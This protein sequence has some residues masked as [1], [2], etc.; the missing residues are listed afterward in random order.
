LHSRRHLA[1]LLDHRAAGD[2][3][4]LPVVV[5]QSVTVV[6]TADA[7]TL[8]CDQGTVVAGGSLHCALTISALDGSAVVLGPYDETTIDSTTGEVVCDLPP[9]AAGCGFETQGHAAVVPFTVE[10]GA[11]V[12]QQTVTAQIEGDS[13]DWLQAN[14]ASA[15]FT[16]VAPTPSA[17]PVV[18][19]PATPAQPV[20]RAGTRTTVSCGAVAYR[21]AG[22]C[23][24]TVTATGGLP[25][26][27]VQLVP[28]SGSVRLAAPGCTLVSGRCSVKVTPSSRPGARVLMK[29]TYAGADTF[30]GSAG[31]GALTVA[32]VRTTTT[33]HCARS[34]LARHG[35]VSCT[36]SVRT[37]FGAAAGLPTA[38]QVT[39]SAHGDRIVYPHGRS[40]AWKVHGKSLVCA[41]TVKAS[42][43]T[44]V[45]VVHVHYRGGRTTHDGASTGT[46]KLTVRR[47]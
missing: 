38:A 20:A 42:A 44:G 21:H 17:Q 45:R 40:C 26:G 35:S 41:F 2:S 37:Q 33:V 4:N 39:V 1:Q 28:L 23:R 34:T 11:A 27:R 30:G 12:G 18:S 31:L 13:V 24:V 29:A 36:A 6:P 15:T 32:A 16:T 9:R 8:S 5:S 43:A 47:S 19:P 46:V 3:H 14:S 25:S 22:S 7:A 10:L